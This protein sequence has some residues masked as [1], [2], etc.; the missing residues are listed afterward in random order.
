MRKCLTEQEWDSSI[1][2]LQHLVALIDE[3]LVAVEGEPVEGEE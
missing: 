3:I 2:R 1:D